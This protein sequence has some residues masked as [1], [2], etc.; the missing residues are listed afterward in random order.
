MTT[1][2][3]NHGSG[4][5]EIATRYTRCSFVVVTNGAYAKY[6]N[7]Y[8]VNFHMQADRL[9]NFAW[10]DMAHLCTPTE[11]DGVHVRLRDW[12]KVTK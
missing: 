2:A 8:H 6:R 7:K 3:G 12:L 1:S 9:R 5:L 4:G 10:F 11:I